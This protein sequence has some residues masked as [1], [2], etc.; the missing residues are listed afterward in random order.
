MTPG[1]LR[2]IANSE[3]LHSSYVYALHEYA[4]RIEVVDKI[5]NSETEE[6]QMPDRPFMQLPTGMTSERLNE[7]ASYIDNEWEEAVEPPS[8]VK[9]LRRWAEEI[10]G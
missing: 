3:G 8:A 1:L 2:E 4:D 5:L 10:G 9:D 6:E 7:I